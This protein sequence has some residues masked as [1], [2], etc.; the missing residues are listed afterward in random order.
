[1]TNNDTVVGVGKKTITDVTSAP[2]YRAH[3][4]EVESCLFP[5]NETFHSLRTY[6]F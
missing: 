1:L 6:Q 4:H 5:I 2:L 3:K